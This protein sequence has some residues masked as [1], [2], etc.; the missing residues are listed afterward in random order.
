MPWVALPALA[1]DSG[2]DEALQ[3]RCWL[4]ADCEGAKGIWGKGN[5][6]RGNPVYGNGEN[7]QWSVENCRGTAD[8]ETA[9]CFVG[10]TNIDLQV[11]IPGFG[12]KVTGGFPQY[13]AAFYKFF[14]AMLA[15]VAVVMVMWGGFKRIMA[16]GSPAKITDAND[17]IVSAISGLVI[18]L[19]SYSL[20]SLVNPRLVLNTLPPI[21]MVKPDF[22]GFCPKYSENPG[23]YSV[24]YYDKTGK[25]VG[26]DRNRMDCYQNSDCPGGGQC[27]GSSAELITQRPLVTCGRT[28]VVNGNECIGI[29][30]DGGQGCFENLYS[31][32]P[33]YACSNYLIQGKLT[34]IET[35]YID[36]QIIC[37][38]TNPASGFD[39]SVSE[40]NA[41][42][43][44]TI[45]VEGKSAY[46]VSNCWGQGGGMT[47]ERS[48]MPLRPSALCSSSGGGKGYALLVEVE[49]SGS[50]DWYAVDASSCQA[51]ETKH[52]SG[53][54]PS[55][56]D[57]KAAAVDRLDWGAVPASSLIPESAILNQDGSIRTPFVCD[58]NITRANFPDR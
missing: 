13:L 58:L 23:L 49:S 6:F 55:A 35:N 31:D 9:R 32:S 22:F 4:E 41:P 26:G 39:C 12:S 21:E 48:Y 20:L 46:A 14:V 24:G 40:P 38:N 34:G 5:V 15:V 19:L 8:V 42:N 2:L 53:S 33:K 43:V 7:D 52:I 50:D 57:P 11:P 51:G 10:S 17:T 37:N 45:D 29:E 44:S 27:G 47:G 25:C 16:A 56:S 36:L 28:L 30:C 3:K 1:A 18:A 54:S